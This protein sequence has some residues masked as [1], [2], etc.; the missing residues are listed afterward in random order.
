MKS[1][2]TSSLPGIRMKSLPLALLVLLASPAYAAN[3]MDVYRDAQQQDAAYASARAAYEAGQEK[4]PQG[5]ALLLPSINLSANTS[6]N[7]VDSPTT[8][9]QYNANGYNL[10]L[11]QPVYRKQNFAQYEQSKSQVVQAEAQ[12][13]VARQDLIVRVAQAYFDVLLA[14]D[15]VALAGAQKAAIGEQLEMAKRNFEVGTVTITDTHEAQARFDLTTAQEIAA[16]NDLEFK[17]R[18]L[19][20]ILGKIPAHLN[21][22]NDKLPLVL[23]E[24]N[25]MTK[26]VEQAEQQ[27][28]QIAIQRAALEIATQEVERNRGGHHPTLDLVAGYGQNSNS[29]YLVSGTVTSQT[30]GLQLNLP[31]FQGGSVNSKVR[32]AL[33]NKEKARQD[34]ELGN[35][36]AALQTRQAFLGVT[37][38]LAQVKALEQALVSSQSSLDSTRLGQEVG[39]RT[40]VDVLNAQQQLYTAK[41]DLSQARYN[42]IISQLKL[43]SAVGA[44]QDE[45]VEQVNRWLGK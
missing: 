13:A 37:S 42:Y 1:R 43:K 33:A 24:P 15:N 31:I 26:W 27:S 36:Q 38:G 41:R 28:P 19:Q 22:L 25:D 35:R 20:L 23:P 8:N 44:L 16:Q 2:V 11:T 9:R 21:A 29:S 4:A 18:A 3:L 7:E 34:L 14:Q 39:V 17:N 40:N 5:L 12:F 6:R 32:E 10:S 30:V 45:D